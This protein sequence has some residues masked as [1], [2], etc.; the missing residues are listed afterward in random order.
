[1]IS[2][3]RVSK[4]YRTGSAAIAVLRVSGTWSELR[5]RQ[6]TLVD[7]KTAKTLSRDPDFESD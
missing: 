4:H 6:A 3:D 2:L 7:F 1:M 5:A